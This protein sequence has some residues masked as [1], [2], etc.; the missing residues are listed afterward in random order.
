MFDTVATAGVCC[1]TYL[2]GVA[3][4]Q[5]NTEQLADSLETQRDDHDFRQLS[6]KK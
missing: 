3:A 6:N 5:R 4:M 1:N 2:K